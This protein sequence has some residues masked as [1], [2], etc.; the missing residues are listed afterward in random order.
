MDSEQNGYEVKAV[1]DSHLEEAIMAKVYLPSVG[2]PER[3]E[4]E[5]LSETS[6]PIPYVN[7]VEPPSICPG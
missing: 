3:R 2:F 5:V 6:F 1:H 4:G 7:R